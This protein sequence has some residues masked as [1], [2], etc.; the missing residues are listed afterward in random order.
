MS[1]LIKIILSFF[2][3]FFETLKHLVIDIFLYL[4]DGILAV[5]SYIIQLMATLMPSLTIGVD[6][7]HKFP[8]PTTAICWLTWIFPVDVLFQC[9]QFYLGLYMLKFLSNPILRFL[10]IVK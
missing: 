4:L 10:K 7:A 9:T 6:L 1:N 2:S 3:K 5:I 8:T